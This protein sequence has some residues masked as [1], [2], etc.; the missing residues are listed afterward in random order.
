[1]PE[2][3]LTP[4][5]FRTHSRSFFCPSSGVC[6][7]DFPPLASDK[8]RYAGSSHACLT[9]L[10]CPTRPTRPTAEGRVSIIRVRVSVNARSDRGRVVECRA[11]RRGGD[12]L[13]TTVCEHRNACGAFK[14]FLRGQPT[15]CRHSPIASVREKV[16]P[17]TSVCGIFRGIDHATLCA[18]DRLAT[19]VCEHRNASG[20]FER[21]RKRLFAD[22]HPQ[23]F[24]DVVGQ[25]GQ[26]CGAYHKATA[27][28]NPSPG[29][30]SYSRCR[31]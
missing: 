8:R 17:I 13:A 2:I 10:T 9:G 27:V 16:L 15:V 24:V 31:S 21:Y 22:F 12:R 7:A 23:T 26:V 3:F 29:V 25:V 4:R 18:G 5:A 6:R 20:A 19:T 14:R 30:L 11:L 1:M 28:C